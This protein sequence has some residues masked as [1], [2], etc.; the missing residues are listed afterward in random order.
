MNKMNKK[1][2]WGKFFAIIGIIILIILI[3]AGITAYQ[4]YNLVKTAQQE[5]PLIQAEAELLMKGDCTKIESIEQRIKNIK[6]EAKNSCKNPIIKI[7]VEKIEKI[8]IKCNELDAYE[9][10]FASTIKPIREYCTNK[11]TQ[12]ITQMQNLTVN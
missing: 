10:Q 4:A 6:T 5:T 3:I 9:E 8:P 7:A 11:T 1:S 12:E 2:F